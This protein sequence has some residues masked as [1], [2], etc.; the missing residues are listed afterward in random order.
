MKKVL[1]ILLVCIVSQTV[2]AQSP[3]WVDK[4]KQ[5][6]FSVVTYDANDKI[7][8][9]GNGFFVTDNGVA[10]SDYSIFKGAQRAVIINS[11]GKQMAVESILGANEMYDV[12]KFRVAITEKKVPMLTIAS[13]G[14]SVGAEVYLLPYSTQKDK[15][16]AIGKVKEV[17]KIGD[18][19]NYYTLNLRLKDKMVSCPITNAEGQVFGIAQKATGRDTTEICYAVSAAYAMAQTVNGLS[20][21]D[22]TLQ[23]V[24]IKLGLP[25]TEEQALIFLFLASSQLS[26]DQYVTLLDDFIKLYPNNPEGYTRKAST[27]MFNNPTEASFAQA[28]NEFAQALKV[29]NKKDEVYYTMSRQIY[30]YQLEHPENTYNNWTYDAALDNINK[31]LAI[32]SLPIYMQLAGDILFAKRD[33]PEAYNWYSKVNKTNLASSSTYYS[34]AKTKELMGADNQEIIALLDSCIAL[35]PEPMTVVNATYLLERAQMYMNTEQYRQ[36]IGDYD[37]Y[38]KVVNGQVND[39]FYYY[40]EQAAMKARQYQR[41]LD[42]IAKAIE[43][44][45][46]ELT[47]MAEQ[48]VVNM[49]VGRTS[50]A[51]AILQNAI[52]I[53]P[54]YAEAYRLMGVCQVQ[55]KNTSEACKNF[56]KAKELGDTN[57]DDLIQKHCK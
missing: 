30:N 50:E 48:A 16:C 25:D 32:D 49:R 38:F 31:A 34:A 39:L 5:A 17:S 53:D 37:A 15:S 14:P 36:A 10:L 21:N 46:S 42:D 22:R 18:K 44:N 9:S 24:G 7:L 54:D 51:V 57:V 13:D 45:P 19:Y 20:L 6:V 52:K 43:L 27:L 55:L 35:A 12:I 26:N 28:A 1:F 4:A 3:K 8:N 11:A 2:K 29:A 33:Y 47:Y 41:A 56:M 40:R 23:N